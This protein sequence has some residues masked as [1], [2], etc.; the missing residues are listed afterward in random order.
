[1][2]QQD[3]IIPLKGTID[4]LSFYKSKDGYM[5]RK[6]TSLTAAKMAT[7]P[8]FARTRETME[9]FKNA[10]F[11]GKLLRTALRPLSKDVSDHRY[12]SRLVRQMIA[13]I[14]ADKTSIRGKRNVIDGEA[15]LLTGFEF[16][17]NGKL[18]TTFFAPYEAAI[19]RT[20]GQLQVKVPPFVPQSMISAPSGATHF[21]IQIA[22]L[23]VDFANGKFAIDIKRSDELPWGTAENSEIHL[24]TT[25]PANST[26]PLFLAMAVS[27][28]I[29]TN[30][31]KYPLK[32]GAYNALAIVMV[33]G[34]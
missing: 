22:G 8:A 16:N 3:G 11:A 20:T 9:E 17:Q 6:K 7:H 25:V 33:S 12:V 28:S 34:V 2:A 14:Q 4:K 31:I 19:D 13:V 15:E 10:G 27:F 23:E 18:A 24:A 1:M 32:S 29:E 21:Q 5:A 30:G 26:H